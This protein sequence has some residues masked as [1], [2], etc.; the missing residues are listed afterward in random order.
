DQD[1]LALGD[2]IGF[3]SLV[4]Q[5]GDFEHGPMHGQIL[6]PHVNGQA[7]SES[8]EAEHDS[9]QQQ[10]VAVDSQEAYRREV[11]EFEAGLSTLGT[12]L[13]QGSG[14]YQHYRGERGC[15]SLGETASLGRNTCPDAHEDPPKFMTLIRMTTRL[16]RRIIPAPLVGASGAECRSSEHAST[17]R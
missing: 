3:A 10:L 5:F 11:R 1:E 9:D 7:E 16:R 14:R 6:Q 17:A 4:D 2:E 8:K 12:G 13:G 15:E